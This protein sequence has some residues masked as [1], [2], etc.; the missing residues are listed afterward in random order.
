MSGCHRCSILYWPCVHVWHQ[1]GAWTQ[2]G[3]H[4]L[5]VLP[6]CSPERHAGSSDA[7]QVAASSQ[8]RDFLVMVL[9]CSYSCT[10]QPLCSIDNRGF[11]GCRIMHLLSWSNLDQRITIHAQLAL[12]NADIRKNFLDA[13]SCVCHHLLVLPPGPEQHTRG[14][15]PC[16][17]DAA[18]ILEAL[19]A[20]ASC[21]CA[22]PAVLSRQAP[23][24]V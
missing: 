1:Q 16:H 11:H 7:A 3:C 24:A 17:S 6:N 4:F 15:Q 8:H 9:C 19:G 23:A 5:L 18:R 12:C 22:A 10:Y 21:H 13:G 14:P 2:P 20:P